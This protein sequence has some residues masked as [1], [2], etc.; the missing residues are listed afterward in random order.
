MCYVGFQPLADPSFSEGDALSAGYA[1]NE[2][3]YEDHSGPGGGGKGEPSY[4]G[5]E[6]FSGSMIA[7]AETLIAQRTG[8]AREDSDHD[9]ADP[10]ALSPLMVRCLYALQLELDSLLPAA[11]SAHCR[12]WA[13]ER[14]Y[15]KAKED[16]ANSEEALNEGAGSGGK[17]SK[18]SA[19]GAAASSPKK[20][21]SNSEVA[22]AEGYENSTLLLAMVDAMNLK[23]R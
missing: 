7:S 20:R 12:L 6:S 14:Y 1:L 22:K 10:F 2:S 19:P 3:L 16:I 13:E 17:E 21:D 8:A 4:C 15:L 11:V 18:Q 5:R 9:I 23:V